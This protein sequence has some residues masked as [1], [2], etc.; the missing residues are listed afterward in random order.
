MYIILLDL[1]FSLDDNLTVDLTFDT[2]IK[3]KCIGACT[4]NTMKWFKN[5]QLLYNNTAKNNNFSSLNYIEVNIISETEQHLKF[6]NGA[7]F[8]INGTYG[9]LVDDL[10]Y[11][12]TIVQL[13]YSPQLTSNLGKFFTNVKARADLG[14]NFGLLDS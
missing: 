13:P 14:T 12:E 9:C 7:F 3:C 10:F 4:N 5:G 1:N 6:I 2:D 11:K 8:E